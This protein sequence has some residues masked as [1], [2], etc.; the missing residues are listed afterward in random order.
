M[1]SQLEI[2]EYLGIEQVEENLK[3]DIYDKTKRLIDKMFSEFGWAA[4]EGRIGSG[5]TTTTYQALRDVIEQ[6]SLKI[7]IVEL[8]VPDRKGIKAT[9]ILSE[10]V[11]TLGK[12]Y[13]GSDVPRHSLDA[14]T[15]QV[16][17][18]LMA[19]REQAA[20][21]LLV[22]DEAHEL[23]F[24]TLNVIKRLRDVTFLQKS[25]LLPVLFMGQPG[26]MGLIDSNEEV[27]HR[28][29][30]GM[31]LE[32]THKPKELAQIL[33]YRSRD[34]LSQAE[35]ESVVDALTRTENGRTLLPTPLELDDYLSEAMERAYKADHHTLSLR[36]FNLPDVTPKKS[37]PRKK[38]SIVANAAPD[39][40]RNIESR[41]AS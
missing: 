18:I 9:H 27:R 12:E 1:T 7:K 37:A 16:K 6:Y 11:R 21:A 17:R 32:F 15:V 36:H 38:V 40:A 13:D 35:C 19:M 2:F 33:K 39:V 3:T 10:F 28:I 5:K 41:S 30:R 31:R 26:L 4:I 23:E 14:R 24:K 22:V 8:S 25:I 34:L 29:K 20:T